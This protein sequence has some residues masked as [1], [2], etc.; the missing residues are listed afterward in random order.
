MANCE[1]LGDMSLGYGKFVLDTGKF[2]LQYDH[3]ISNVSPNMYVSWCMGT[4][5]L[6][7]L[8]NSG[9]VWFFSAREETRLGPAE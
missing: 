7:W 9:M 3:S 5:H 8:E 1:I 6:T 4:C 2:P